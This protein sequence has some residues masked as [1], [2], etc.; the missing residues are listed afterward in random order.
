MRAGKCSIPNGALPVL[1]PNEFYKSETYNLAWLLIRIMFFVFALL[2]GKTVRTDG[3]GCYKNCTY[4]STAEH[5]VIGLDLGL[6]NV[7]FSSWDIFSKN[8][9][10]KR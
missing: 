9:L 2:L 3:N 10:L 7:L 5:I 8:P 4:Y 1:W 6:L